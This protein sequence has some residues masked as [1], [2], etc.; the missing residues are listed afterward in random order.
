MLFHQWAPTTSPNTRKSTFNQACHIYIRTKSNPLDKRLSAFIYRVL[1]TSA[2]RNVTDLAII[3]PAIHT[4][5]MAA[6][7]DHYVP[8][9]V[10]VHDRGARVLVD[11]LLR[12]R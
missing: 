10:A 4:V 12:A 1:E 6:G 8:A 7:E 9:C 2:K 5:V 11:H 3:I